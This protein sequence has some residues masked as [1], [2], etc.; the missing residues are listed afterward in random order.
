MNPTYCSFQVFLKQI[1]RNGM[2]A[3]IYIIPIV[4][5]LLFKIVIPLSN[6][7]LAEATGGEWTLSQYYT[8]IDMLLIVMTPYLY[9]FVSS[10]IIFDELDENTIS[11]L[12]IS[13]IG[14]TGY[15]VSRLVI[16]SLC[17][18]IISLII[19]AVCSL[20]DMSLWIICIS[21]FLITLLCIITCLM[22]VSFAGNKVEGMALFKFAGLIFSGLI[23]PFVLNTPI[24]YLFCILPSFWIGKTVHS[25]HVWFILSAL[26][27][28]ACWAFVL[29]RIFRQK[30]IQAI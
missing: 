16:P 9:C 25:P 14:K 12:I 27:C 24:Q 6:Q 4:T 23:I 8:L 21:T 19:T 10:M 18:G 15:L 7:Y 3:I 26:L 11:S 22:V 13:P 5:I 28:S 29:F 20:S 1:H 17:G 30:I 2:S